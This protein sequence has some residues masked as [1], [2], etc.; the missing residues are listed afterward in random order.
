MCLLANMINPDVELD[1]EKITFQV[2]A[3]AKV[4]APGNPRKRNHP[5]DP[6]NLYCFLSNGT[7]CKYSAGPKEAKSYLSG[8]NNNIAYNDQSN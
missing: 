6:S 8:H 3:L 7:P 5:D 2:K 4:T 1:K